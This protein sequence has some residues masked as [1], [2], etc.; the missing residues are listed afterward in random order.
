MKREIKL[1]MHAIPHFWIAGQ[2]GRTPEIV[3][4][5]HPRF[6]SCFS[7]PH[8]TKKYQPNHCLMQQ[9][10]NL[11]TNERMTINFIK[12][13][14]LKVTHDESYK[15]FSTLCYLCPSVNQIEE[16]KKPS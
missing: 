1:E 6:I 14:H 7:C 5:P 15:N 12:Y 4:I 11:N 2:K 13:K 10:F 16:W 9:R 8:L 3:A